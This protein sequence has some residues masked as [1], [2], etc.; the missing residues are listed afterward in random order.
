VVH[1]AVARRVYGGLRLGSRTVGRAAGEAAAQ[2][3]TAPLSS[4]PVGAVALGVLNGLIGDQLERDGSA[5]GVPMTL[6]VEGERTPRLVVFLH[7]LMESDR[8][9]AL[10]GGP[11]YGERLA[12][13]LGLTA[14][15]VHYNTGRNHPVVYERLHAWLS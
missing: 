4:T 2:L 8:S 10:G 15:Y 6:R 5:L 7:G 3:R 14:V 12:Q 1:D 13:Q 9:W 11:T